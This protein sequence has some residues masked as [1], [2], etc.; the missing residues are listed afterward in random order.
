MNETGDKMLV[1]G[2]LPNHSYNI[3]IYDL[4]AGSWELLQTI[5]SRKLTTVKMSLDGSRIVAVATYSN[6]N[7]APP[8]PPGHTVYE[9]LSGTFQIIHSIDYDTA[10]KAE[11]IDSN[12][13][14]SAHLGVSADG[15]RFVTGGDYGPV[16]GGAFTYKGQ[17]E[18]WE[19]N[20]SSTNATDKYVVIKHWDG[21]DTDLVGYNPAHGCS[22]SPDGSFVGFNGESA[23]YDPKFFLYGESAGVW[24]LANTE[25]AIGYSYFASIGFSP[26]GEYLAVA[27]H[28]SKNTW[29]DALPLIVFQKTGATWA[30]ISSGFALDADVPVFGATTKITNDATLVASG[31]NFEVRVYYYNA[32]EGRYYASFAV[33]EGTVS[34]GMMMYNNA[35]D[36]SVVGSELTI[37]NGNKVK[38]TVKQYKTL[39]R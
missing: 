32:A 26:N 21:G 31:Q 18:V 23:V 9:F 17:I 24:T 33:D 5:H 11:S 39:L 4:V 12:T 16:V 37:M 7:V 8:T 34:S 20:P 6:N 25:L 30:K 3:Y 38:G 1:T 22:I 10:G 28:G 29:S 13:Y 19:V 35:F 15:S 36:V 2:R 27:W 14:G